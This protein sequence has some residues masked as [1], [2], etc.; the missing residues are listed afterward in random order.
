MDFRNPWTET[1]R[2]RTP[3]QIEAIAPAADR[4]AQRFPVLR[5]PQ[6]EVVK[7]FA[8]APEQAFGAG[9]LLFDVGSR[10]VPVWFLLQGSVDAFGRD[11][12]DQETAI[13]HLE[14]GQFTGELNQL[15]NRPSLAGA[16]AGP[17]G[18]VALP[19][20]PTRLR[21]LIVG[22]AELGELI[23]RAFILRRVSLLERG[24]GPVI[25]GRAG[26][27]DVLRLQA[28]L[29]RNTYPH[30]VLTCASDRGRQLIEDLALPAEDL[31][32]VVCPCGRVLKRPSN[33]ATGAWLGITPTLS[34]ET[35]YDV[36]V[37]GSGPAGLAT[38]VYAASEG[39]SV[40]VLDGDVLGGQAGASARIENY[41]GFPTGIS[42]QALTGRALNQAQKFGAQVAIPLSATQ[43]R[44]EGSAAALELQL[45][46]QGTLKARTVVV[47]TGARYR[48]PEIEN[49]RPFEGNSVHYWASPVE[50]T[51]CA[52]AEIALVGAGN[53]AGQ[54]VVFL[55]PQVKRLTLIVRGSGLE[56]SMS[57]YL[58]DRIKMLDNV[59][60]QVRSEVVELHGTRGG[61]L[62]GA[63]IRNRATGTTSRLPLSQLF[64]FIGA[65]P[66]TS[67][68]DGCVALDEHGYILTGMQSP[69]AHQG[70]VP[71][72]LQTSLPR[73]F[74]IGDVR[75]GSTKR[76]ASAVGEGAAVVAQ[77]HSILSAP[78]A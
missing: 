19:L 33:E 75:S 66:N 52:G 43:L 68:L 7:R 18:C 3:E 2:M 74:A 24:V 31:P 39:L 8:G 11:G 49:L 16:R 29:T 35:V 56:A 76:V 6:L 41:L 69:T 37:I 73:V 47:A 40:L 65:A 22:S 1:D 51:L 21:T 10:D 45:S 57:R 59:D 78:A 70:S 14:R 48:R 5:E 20:D 9:E 28:F 44:C 23:M 61:T 17:D 25:L 72:P 15:A 64:L 26:S 58:I 38:A 27:A 30:L 46:E 32:V 71:L 62:E 53:S 12:L 67:W 4:S 36:A 50:A 54:A 42:G 63:T 13:R 77:I 55:A 60:I 34:T